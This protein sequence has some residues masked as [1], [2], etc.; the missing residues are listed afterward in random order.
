MNTP[1]WQELLD[2]QWSD[3]YGERVTDHVDSEAQT[4][5][6]RDSGTRATT[7]STHK[8]RLAR[9]QHEKDWADE[10]DHLLTAAVFVVGALCVI[11][12][13]ALYGV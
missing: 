2:G 11:V 3:G 7:A 9:A 1:G 12:A 5:V 13:L 8:A 6:P 10:E 4:R